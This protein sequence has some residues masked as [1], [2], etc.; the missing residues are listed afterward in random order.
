MNT[1]QSERKTQEQVIRHFSSVLDYKFLGDWSDRANNSNVEEVLLNKYL[2]GKGYSET[3]INKAIWKLQQA[4]SNLN[5]GLYAANK[6]VYEL[7]RYGC[8]VSESVSKQTETVHLID[9]KNPLQNHF[10]I[11]EEVTIKDNRE[12]RPDIVLYINGIA[13]GVLELKKSTKGIGEGIRQNLTNQDEGFIPSF[14]TSIQFCFAGNLSE[15][16]RYGTIGTK[17]KYYLQWKEDEPTEL[18]EFSLF[19]HLSKIC[20]K[21][22]IIELMYDFVLFD[23]G[24]KKL[25]R[26]HQYF[27][28]KAAQENLNFNVIPNVGRVLNPAN[29]NR[30]GGIIWH[31]QGSGK[32][33]TMVLLAKWILENNSNARIAI[34]TDRDELDKQIKSVFLG[35]G[36]NVE[37]ARSGRALQQL[38]EL[39]Q[40][41]LICSLVHKFGAKARGVDNFDAFLNDMKANSTKLNGDFY[42][43]VDECHRT[44]SGRLHQVMKAMLPNAVFIGFTGTPLLKKDK[45]TSLEVF[46]KYIHTYKFHE[47]VTDGVV[48]DLVYEARDIDQRISSQER[49]DN[50]FA[51]KTQKLNDFQTAELKKKWGTMQS[52]LS[53]NSRTEKIVVN[54][55]E[56]FSLKPRLSSEKGNAILV[57]HNIYEACKFYNAFQK[58]FFKGKCAIITSYNPSHRDIVNEETGE[59]TET[60]K[61]YIYNTYTELLKGTT[62]DK[63]EE[64]AKGKFIKEAANMKIL[65]VVDK[66]LTGFDAPSCSYLYI[67]KSMRDHSLF[68][69]ICRVNRLDS[70]DK[71][72]GYIVDYRDLFTSV[73]NAISVYTSELEYDAFDKKDCDILL[74]SRLKKAKE[75]LD[76]AL[77][78]AEGLCE[79]VEN[80]KTELEYIRYFCGNPEDAESLKSRA[81]FR[82]ELY[83]IIVALIRAYANISDE[84]TEAG[85][86]PKEITHIENRCKFYLELRELIKTAS[87]EKLDIKDYEADMRHLIDHYIQ[88]ED[89]RKVSDFESFTLLEII[90][91]MGI[92][93]ALE[94]LPEGIKRNKETIA[95]TIENNVR[96]KIIKDQLSNP[97]FFENMSALLQE[98]IKLRREKAISYEEYLQRV[99]EIAQQTQLGETDTTPRQ[100]NSPAKRALYYSLENDEVLALACDEAVRYAKKADWK[101]N[102]QKENEIKKALYGT[103]NDVKKVNAIFD[104]VKEQKEYL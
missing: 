27:G 39:P 66:L 81:F 9:W 90:S 50:W 84:L 16:L 15:G 4:A 63:Y 78:A 28:I 19:R 23:G 57:A 101:G 6:A 22:R 103:L 82:T 24:V 43:F 54:I 86:T 69:A 36:Q 41:R 96:S 2:Q 58:T 95:E 53:S 40:H 25:P 7:L 104:V 100:I 35:A 48:L 62:T 68:Q 85:Y 17:A 46:G 42:I 18:T 32:S 64:A 8:S 38:L 73:E 11:A 92:E 5:N 72:L 97:V 77:E 99:A 3:L 70:E 52:V 55:I 26:P 12:K 29:V 47:A 20:Q 89:A 65:V 79:T 10:A 59:N 87:C 49:I 30:K 33:I 1:I 51:I 44:Q 45:Q 80:P 88:A 91:K 71:E 76:N 14:F 37:K 74:E 61:Q 31:T 102:P 75:R 83:R 56:D 67:D 34:I 21:E 98:L 94:N 93:K 13:L 60:E